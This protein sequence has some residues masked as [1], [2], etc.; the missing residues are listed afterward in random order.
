MYKQLKPIPEEGIILD[1]NIKRKIKLSEQG[2]EVVR[3]TPVDYIE[4][5]KVSKLQ[6]VYEKYITQLKLEQRSRENEFQ[7]LV[8][9]NKLIERNSESLNT[10]ILGLGVLLIVCFLLIKYYNK[11]LAKIKNS[12]LPNETY[13]KLDTKETIIISVILGIIS[14]LLVGYYTGE[15]QYY[16][17]KGYRTMD[18][19]YSIKVF[20][21]NYLLFS[22]SCIV[23]SGI[24]YLYLSKK[25]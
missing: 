4:L 8:Q 14:G 20:R 9:K 2:K 5:G 23:I 10:I 6:K 24:S 21:F 12:H 3:N 15:I 11:I 7:I 13:R 16:T 1:S 19:Y 22:C 18:S 17:S 25:K